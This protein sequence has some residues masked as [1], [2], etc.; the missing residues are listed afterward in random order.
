[1]RLNNRKVGFAFG[2]ATA[3]VVGCAVTLT[4]FEWTGFG[5][6][7]SQDFS[8]PAGTYGIAWA[9][10]DEPGPPAGC[11]FELV[12]DRAQD[13]RRAEQPLV[14]G[15]STIPKLSYETTGD[16]GTIRGR[17]SLT[18]VAQTYRFHVEGT[19]AWRVTVVDG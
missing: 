8:L 1:V 10:D 18:L 6:A 15:V 3:I 17:T 9:A 7:T 13:V 2:V 4:R 12:L 11:R 14:P 19:C 5:A 16:G